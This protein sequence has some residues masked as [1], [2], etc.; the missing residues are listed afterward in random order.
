MRQHL[1]RLEAPHLT[2]G[3]QSWVS[4]G[5][6]WLKIKPLR[7]RLALLAAREASVMS[8]DVRL[9]YSSRV[10]AGCRFVSDERVLIVE[11]V[12]NI[13]ARKNWLSCHCTETLPVARNADVDADVDANVDS[14]QTNDGAS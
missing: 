6:V 11:N 5:D 12:V 4:L 7:G 2:K 9:R 13:G 10:K 3:R 1:F 14:G 8:Y